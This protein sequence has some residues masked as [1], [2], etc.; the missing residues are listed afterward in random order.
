[1]KYLH[2]NT[3]YR[4]A[5]LLF[6]I[7]LGVWCNT[8]STFA[9][10]ANKDEQHLQTDVTQESED[11][12]SLPNERDSIMQELMSEIQELKLQRILM[13]EEL[14]KTGLN[15]RQDSIAQ[16]VRKQRIDSLRKVIIGAPLIIDKDTLFTLYA[17]K[18]GMLPEARVRDCKKIIEALGHKLTFY[19]DSVYTYSGD[20]FTDIMVNEEVVLS[21]TDTDALWQDMARDELA[22]KYAKIVARTIV[23]SEDKAGSFGQNA[24]FYD[25]AE[26]FNSKCLVFLYEFGVEEVAGKYAQA[27][28]AFFR[29]ACVGVKN[30]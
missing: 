22:E 7:I 30:S 28:A 24:Y 29:L 11:S 25:A 23:L 3:T 14:E 13:Q 10:D 2:T 20:L 18:G 17:R 9:Q 21:I 19:A 15:A 27:V 8:A 16:A 6:I 12:T 4:H 26:G 5:V 1:M